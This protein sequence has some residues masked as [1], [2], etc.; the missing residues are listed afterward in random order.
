[1]TFSI[2]CR[3]EKRVYLQSTFTTATKESNNTG[4]LIV[5]LTWILRYLTVIDCVADNCTDYGLEFEK[6]FS[7]PGD[8]AMLNSTLLTWSVFNFSA[9]PYNITWYNSATGKEMT[10]Q[11]SRILVR[12]ET[13]WFLN[14]TEEDAG[15]YTTIVR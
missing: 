9:V 7:V 10:T 13:L 3:Q 8:V 12:G 6:V 4:N 11:T 15:K 1:M 5:R 2:L 14:V